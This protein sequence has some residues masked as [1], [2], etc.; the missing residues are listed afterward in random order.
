[1]Y[2]EAGFVICFLACVLIAGCLLIFITFG[3]RRIRSI[4]KVREMNACGKLHLFNLLAEPF[5]FSYL[6]LQDLITTREDAW[7]RDFGYHAFFDRSASHFHMVL[8]CE[9][10]Y[11]YYAGETWLIEFWKG[12][13]GIN[14]GGEIGIYHADSIL[15]P[16]QYDHALFQSVPDEK[17]LPLSMELFYKGSLLFGIRRRHWW[18]TGFR[19]GRYCEPEDLTMKASLTFPDVAMLNSFVKSLL[20]M[21]YSQN[22]VHVREFTVSFSFAVPYT[23]QYR[24]HFVYYSRW[25]QWKNRVLCKIYQWATKPFTCTLDQMLYLYYCLPFVFRYMLHFRKNK[26]QKYNRKGRGSV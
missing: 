14:V 23:L 5:G 2:L 26:E 21:G 4:Q 24:K 7:Q 6:M 25:T 8:D 18:L 12:Q 11:F 13:Y 9:P 10:V 15:E 22:E 3:R 20:Y 19:M 16:E 1:M 17:M